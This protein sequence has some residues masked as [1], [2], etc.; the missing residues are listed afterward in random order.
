MNLKE[1]GRGR[2]TIDSGA[3][4]SVLPKNLLP[5]EPIEEGEAKRRG[6]K[7]VAANG[8]KL[9]NMGEK[10]VKVKR[11][12]SNAA[13][14]ITFQVTDVSKP[15]ASVSRILDKG[16]AVIFSRSGSYILNDTSSEKIPIADVEF[17]EPDFV[18]R[19]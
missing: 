2:I 1:V 18:W 4:E 17:L 11:A 16:N 3:A 7:Y 9:E 10:K 15:L 8:G 6:V 13:N 5:H 14:S 12:G 19:G